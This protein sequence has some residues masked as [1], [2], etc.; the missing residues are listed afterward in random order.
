MTQ[1]HLPSEPAAR[2]TLSESFTP[3]PT[4]RRAKVRRDRLAAKA[5]RGSSAQG[6]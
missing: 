1:A 6:K 5:L 3:A 2:I 4:A